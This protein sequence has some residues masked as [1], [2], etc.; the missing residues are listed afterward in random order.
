MPVVFQIY[1]Q[2]INF[3]IVKEK[4]DI[5][6]ICE[7]F[8]K[9][10]HKFKLNGYQIYRNDRVIHGGGVAIA[11]RYDLCHDSL[12]NRRT[13]FIENI[14][15]NVYLNGKNVIF[16]SAYCGKY[17]RHFTSDIQCLTSSFSDEYLW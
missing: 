17:S 3:L 5:V 13:V 11:V 2:F 6:L 9:S 1:L 10:H 14:S 4:I 7:T 12:Q 8:L 15:V 16:T